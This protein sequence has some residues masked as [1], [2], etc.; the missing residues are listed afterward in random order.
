[1]GEG[2]SIIVLDTTVH[3]S[4]V[5]MVG[6]YVLFNLLFFPSCPDIMSSILYGVKYIPDLVY[7][8]V[9]N[10]ILSYL[11]SCLYTGCCFSCYY[12]CYTVPL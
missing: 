2:R 11:G 4:V 10:S 3:D 6:V 7:R 8:S 1:M 5:E 12:E 9:R